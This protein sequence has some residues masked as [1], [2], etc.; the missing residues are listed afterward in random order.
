MENNFSQI[1]LSHLKQP[2]IIG[3]AGDSGS[4]KTRFSKGIRQLLGPER[5]FTIEMDGYHKENREERKKSGRLPLDP[6]MNHLDL[7]LTHLQQ[8]KEGKSIQLPIYNHDSGNF[9][10]PISFSPTPIIILEG[11]FALY[12]EFLPYLDFTIYVDP[13]RD[14]KWY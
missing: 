8:L 11:L 14:V 2:I 7:V 9:D 10:P 6:A 1:N 5:V 13:S 4:G 12:P 3:I